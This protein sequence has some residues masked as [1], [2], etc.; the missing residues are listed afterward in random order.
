MLSRTRMSAGFQGKLFNRAN[1]LHNL[2]YNAYMFAFDSAGTVTDNKHWGRGTRVLPAWYKDGDDFGGPDVDPTGKTE[3]LDH[4]IPM[5]ALI[6]FGTGDFGHF[7]T[8]TD[9]HYN[10]TETK[11]MTPFNLF[12]TGSDDNY[13]GWRQISKSI[14]NVSTT[15][16]DRVPYKDEVKLSS[17]Y[18]GDDV[19]SLIWKSLENVGINYVRSWMEPILKIKFDASKQIVGAEKYKH[20]MKFLYRRYFA[21]GVGKTLINNYADFANIGSDEAFWAAFDSAAKKAGD[22]GAD[23]ILQNVLYVAYTTMLAERNPLTLM[24][25]VT[26][27]TTQTGTTVY[28]QVREK[29]FKDLKEDQFAEVRHDLIA[30]QMEARDKVTEQI[31]ENRKDWESTGTLDRNIYGDFS[32]DRSSVSVTGKPG[33]NGYVVNAQTIEVLLREKLS[34]DKNLT[35]EQIDAGI[36]NAKKLHSGILTSFGERAELPDYEKVKKY[37]ISN[38]PLS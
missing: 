14:G 13:R 2:H 1:A 28:D 6:Q 29:Y 21:E 26:R 37:F 23:S 5:G 35:P 30:V 11:A 16:W 18:K 31:K 27:W 7:L 38:I 9:E 10:G 8:Y 15:L 17:E 20:F 32:K 19:Y 24:N 12:Q 36:E 3:N 33:D 4:T 25:K 22:K 34:K